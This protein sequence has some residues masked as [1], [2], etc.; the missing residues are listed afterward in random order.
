M[1]KVDREEFLLEINKLKAEIGNLQVQNADYSQIVK[2]LSDK[3]GQY[4][5]KYGKVFTSKDS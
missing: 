2:E 5:N 4:Q 1:D 3:L